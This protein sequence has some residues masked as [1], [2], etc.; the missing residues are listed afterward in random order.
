MS[1]STL[2]QLWVPKKGLSP[3]EQTLWDNLNTL[4]SATDPGA[5][6]ISPLEKGERNSLYHTAWRVAKAAGFWISSAHFGEHAFHNDLR[7]GRT[8]PS[9]LKK[10]AVLEYARERN[11]LSPD[12]DFDLADL[13]KRVQE[14]EDR[15]GPSTASTV[16]SAAST[17]V[18]VVVTVAPL[19]RG[20]STG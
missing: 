17:L 4:Y 1:L 14:A 10:L 8:M 16:I 13:A 6:D 7:L 20:Q 18:Q 19:L 3:G 11:V 2:N 15:I 9:A 5:A 12:S